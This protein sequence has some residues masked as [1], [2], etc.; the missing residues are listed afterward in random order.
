MGWDVY[1][2][3]GQLPP[4]AQG[5]YY[6][7]DLIGLDVENLEGVFNSVKLTACLQTGANDIL[8]VKGETGSGPCHSCKGKR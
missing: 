3:H 6:W 7:T 8:V 5:E 1:I 4:P 2:S